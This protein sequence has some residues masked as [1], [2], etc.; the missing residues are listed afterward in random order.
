MEKLRIEA[1][2]G[3]LLVS[4]YDHVMLYSR[5]SEGEMAA[6]TSLDFSQDRNSVECNFYIP[7]SPGLEY[8]GSLGSSLRDVDLTGKNAKQILDQWI[9]SEIRQGIRVDK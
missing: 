1:I 3:S 4:Q 8:T 7:G 2:L 6:K 9:R 5:T